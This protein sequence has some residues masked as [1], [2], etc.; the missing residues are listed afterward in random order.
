MA[1]YSVAVSVSSGTTN[2][3]VIAN[4]WSVTNQIHIREISFTIDAAGTVVANAW[5][6]GWVRSTARG[7]QT[8]TTAGN[9]L[10]SSQPSSV[11]TLDSAWSVNPTVGAASTQLR[12]GNYGQSIGSGVIYQF[13]KGDFTVAGGAG[14]ALVINTTPT[15]AGTAIVYFDWEE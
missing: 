10:S 12:R 14:L 5:D 3:A 11:A 8:T 13:P 1:R 4:L 9:A 15:A 2:G 6:M 7:T